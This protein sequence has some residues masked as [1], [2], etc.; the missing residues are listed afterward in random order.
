VEAMKGE[1]ETDAHE[2]RR[3]PSCAVIIG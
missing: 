1:R 3:P 2:V